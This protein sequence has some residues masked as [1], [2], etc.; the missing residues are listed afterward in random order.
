MKKK[1]PVKVETKIIT[2]TSEIF[3]IIR[4]MGIFV[5][6]KSISESSEDILLEFILADPKISVEML[7]D[8]AEICP[9]GSPLQQI[10]ENLADKLIKKKPSRTFS[11][12]I[13]KNVKEKL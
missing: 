7:T 3:D 2:A 11:E 6:N 10:F 12:P 4:Q 9:S 8:L 13:V 5:S 1:I